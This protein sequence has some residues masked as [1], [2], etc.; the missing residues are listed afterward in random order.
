M[1]RGKL[2]VRTTTT[3]TTT[4]S[5]NNTFDNI[6]PVTHPRVNLKSVSAWSPVPTYKVNLLSQYLRVDFWIA[7]YVYR[8]KPILFC[9]AKMLL[10][11]A[12]KCL[13]LLRHM[14]IDLSILILFMYTVNR[15]QT[16]GTHTHKHLRW[17]A[18]QDNYQKTPKLRSQSQADT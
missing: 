12:C 13:R 16:S 17:P 1:F 8:N 18:L 9:T 10:S 5:E 15:L 7:G 2:P 3:T 14:N 6:E 4:T 11:H